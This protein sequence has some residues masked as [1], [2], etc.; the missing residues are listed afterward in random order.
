MT[1]LSSHLHNLLLKDEDIISVP[2]WRF[3]QHLTDIRNIC[4]HAKAKEPSKQ[5][6]E[7]LLAGTAK[8]LKTIF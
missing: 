4:D 7:D 1:N 2:D 5:E 6:I 3:I 8:V